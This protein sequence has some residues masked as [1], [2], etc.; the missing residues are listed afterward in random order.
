MN[1]K[2]PFLLLGLFL[3]S[4]ASAN[5]GTFQQDTCVNIRTALNTTQVNISSIS[6]PNETVL[7]L[8]NEMTRN[9]K[10]FNYSFCDTGV[11]GEYVY[12]FYD[13]EGNVFVNDFNITYN[14]DDLTNAKAIL[15]AILLAISVF[16][17]FLILYYTTKLPSKNP[18]DDEGL[19]MVSNLKYLRDTLFAVLYLVSWSILFLASNIAIAY[20]PFQMFGNFLFAL[21][22]IMGWLMIPAVILWFLWIFY[23]LVNDAKIKRY[24]NM[25]MDLGGKV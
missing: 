19:V 12:D 11:I 1:K 2:Y 20:L 7:F 9:G 13:L 24:M 15:Y 14:G 25:G 5:L 10:T 23:S 17:W 4:F 16:F 6:Y 3:I 18:R 22:Q 21:W 8:D